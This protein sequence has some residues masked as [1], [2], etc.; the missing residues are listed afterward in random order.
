MHAQC[1]VAAFIGF[2]DMANVNFI[3]DFTFE[4]W[5]WPW[6]VTIENVQ[7]HE[8]HMH[9]TYE[10]PVLTGFEAMA[11]ASFIKGSTFD[12]NSDLDL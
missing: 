8:I 10:A 6:I 2:K 5:P 12:L 7:L 3:E 9:A 11:Y 1:E 4:W